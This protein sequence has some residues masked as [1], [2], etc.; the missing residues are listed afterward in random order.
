MAC[1]NCHVSLMKHCAP[2]RYTHGRLIQT[3]PWTDGLQTAGSRCEA[4]RGKKWESCHYPEGLPL[5]GGR[6]KFCTQQPRAEANPKGTAQGNKLEIQGQETAQGEM[7]APSSC[8]HD[9]LD[10]FMFHSVPLPFHP[11][12]LAVVVNL[13]MQGP[14]KT[15]SGKVSSSP[16][17]VFWKFTN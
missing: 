12:A 11:S 4:N 17:E 1:F 13:P 2:T 16:E 3:V 10:Y 5:S 9:V 14:L 8:R 15:S 7:L 6:K